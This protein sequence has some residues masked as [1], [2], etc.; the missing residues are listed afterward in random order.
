VKAEIA[1]GLLESPK[2]ASEKG[3]VE[4]AESVL[5][6]LDEELFETKLAA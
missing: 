1:N 4:L 5:E 2:R 6:R 3:A